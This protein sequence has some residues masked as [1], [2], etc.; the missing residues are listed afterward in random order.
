[1]IRRCY[2]EEHKKKAI[3]Y[4]GC[5]V[6]EEWLTFSNFKAWMEKQDWEGKNLDKD[7]LGDGKLYSPVTC[8][9]LTSRV[10]N[11]IVL[12]EDYRGNLPI[13][14]IKVGN[15]YKSQIR[16]ENG[17]NKYLGSFGC[18]T[19][20]HM[21]WRKEK[22][23]IALNLASTEKDSRISEALVKFVSGVPYET[24]KDS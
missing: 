8:C 9:F 12:R 16:N 14:V 23:A 17:G 24:T 13:G 21:A 19:A 10:N 3:S 20:A 1:M 22:H 11:F 6:C 15:R 4:N 18:P 2:D 5:E 7:L